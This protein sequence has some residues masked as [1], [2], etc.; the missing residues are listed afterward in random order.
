MPRIQTESLFHIRT[1]SLKS[2]TRQ[3]IKSR[4]VKGNVEGLSCQ[5]R[6]LEKQKLKHLIIRNQ[7]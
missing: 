4:E 2:P 7:S 5:P 6:E 3:Q 1:E